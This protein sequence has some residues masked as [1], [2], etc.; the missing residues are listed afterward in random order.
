MYG[1][2]DVRTCTCFRT[3]Q[4]RQQKWKG[5]WRILSQVRQTLPEPLK[6]LDC[7]RGFRKM[8]LALLIV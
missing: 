5:S 2:V 6:G 3:L 4:E 8:T 1:I 7:G